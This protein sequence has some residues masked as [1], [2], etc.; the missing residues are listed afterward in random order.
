M[1]IQADGTASEWPR[2]FF[3]ESR[4]LAK[5]LMRVRAELSQQGQS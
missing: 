5:R 2:S 4:E 1:S 3:G